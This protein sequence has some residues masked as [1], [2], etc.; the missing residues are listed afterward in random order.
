MFEM[1]GSS[2]KEQKNGKQKEH[3]IEIDKKKMDLALGR[4][5]KRRNKSGYNCG[6]RENS[7]KL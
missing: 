5:Q 3:E 1:K 6:N 4:Y 2:E 7:I